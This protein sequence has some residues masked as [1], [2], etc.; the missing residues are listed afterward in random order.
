MES[1]FKICMPWLYL[2][3]AVISAAAGFKNSALKEMSSATLAVVYLL[4]ASKHDPIIYLHWTTGSRLLA[5]GKLT[6][7]NLAG[8]TSILL[9]I[10]FILAMKFYQ[11]YPDYSVE[12]LL[13]GFQFWSIFSLDCDCRDRLLMFCISTGLSATVYQVLPNIPLPKLAS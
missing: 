8:N 13:R 6:T 12:L 2:N 7:A 5:N 10:V 1:Y 9:C 11:S 4:F 3:Q